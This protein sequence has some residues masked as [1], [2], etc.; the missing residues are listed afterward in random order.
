MVSSFANRRARKAAEEERRSQLESLRHE[1]AARA[2]EKNEK[3]E[4]ARK[5]ALSMTSRGVDRLPDRLKK[6]HRS[7]EDLTQLH[8]PSGA[9]ANRATRRARGYTVRDQM[10]GR[11]S[12]GKA[13]FQ[14]QP[15]MNVPFRNTA[16]AERRAARRAAKQAK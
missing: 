4:K 6:A 3:S 7:P 1:E 9:A 16:K 12:K 14:F 5:E 13:I 11:Y 10:P 2:I 8:Y 15:G